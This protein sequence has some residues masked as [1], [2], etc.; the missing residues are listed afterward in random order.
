MPRRLRL[1]RAPSALVTLAITI[2]A[3]CFSATSA[4]AATSQATVTCPTVNPTTGAVTPGWANGVDWAGCDLSGADLEEAELANAELGGAN[5]TN[6][7]MQGADVSD[8]DMTDANLAGANLMGLNVSDATLTGAAL[9]GAKSGGL[10]GAPIALPADWTIVNGY[11]AGPG[12]DLAYANLLGQDLTGADLTGA[13]L[14]D[15]SLKGTTLAGA[16]LA[17]ATLTGVESGSITGTPAALPPNWTLNTGYL[18]GPGSDLSGAALVNLDLAGADLEDAEVGADLSGANLSGADLRGA[19]LAEANI[20]GTDLAGAALSGE[21]SGGITGTPATFPANWVLVSGY[22]VGP[23]ATLTDVNFAGL[24]LAGDDMAGAQLGSANLEGTALAGSDLSGAN[25][26]NA[27]MLGAN[28]TAADLSSANVSEGDLTD[29]DLTHANLDGANLT[30]A[31]IEGTIVT[32]ATFAGATMTGLVG[33]SL[34]GTPG[35]LPAGW[36]MLDEILLGP[37]ADLEYVNLDSDDLSGADL[38][39]ANFIQASL[40]HTNLSGA[41]L[42]NVDSFE[43]ANLSFA[44][45]AGANLSDANLSYGNFSFVNLSEANLTGA[46]V[47]GATLAGD[48]W[49][50][51]TCPDGSNS[52]AYTDG[53]FSVLDT[54]PPSAAPAVSHGSVG[55]HGWYTSPVTVTWNWTDNGTIDTSRCRLATTTTD[56]GVIKLNSTCQD[57]AGNVGHDAYTVKVDTTRPQVTVSGVKNGG[58]YALG[59]VPHVECHTTDRISGVAKLARLTLRTTGTGGVGIFTATCSGAASQ[60]GT[61]QRAVSARYTVI[62]GFGGFISP[63]AGS[64]ISKKRGTVATAFRLTAYGKPISAKLSR[65]LAG[66]HDIRATLTGRGIK[67]VT[68]IC[69]WSARAREFTCAIKLPSGVKVG[70]KYAYSL[71]AR[72]NVGTGLTLAPATSGASNPETIHFS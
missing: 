43:A 26:D 2:V 24:D 11:F 37:G 57:L 46:A 50:D 49:Y 48:T 19:D 60:A 25:L 62:Y 56:N 29:D 65:A 55:Q 15:A 7:N 63:H 3:A 28:L 30:N 16:V 59:R 64:T 71:S 12:A 40:Q 22:L 39:G 13:D 17:A 33:T 9:S 52:N 18:I 35:D 42:S 14:T 51:T 61:T 72:E 70:R 45:L 47:T 20:S 53:C 69:R 31:S 5:L 23:G 67:P 38:S 68:A 21:Q 54:V 8:T 36:M 44:N 27:L 66:R 6:A 41:N 34:T 58:H 1:M 32:G 4:T 10:V